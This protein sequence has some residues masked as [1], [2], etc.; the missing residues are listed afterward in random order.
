MTFSSAACSTWSDG[1]E[2][3]GA[4][5]AGVTPMVALTKRAH[6]IVEALAQLDFEA[7]YISEP[8]ADA[9]DDGTTVFAVIEQS[10]D[11]L[12]DSLLDAQDVVLAKLPHEDIEFR[13]RESQGRPTAQAKLRN[14]S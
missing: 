3:S 2:W 14:F 7:I 12:Y 13:I 4:D 8:T 9:A 5:A 10:S 6:V 1:E 11:A